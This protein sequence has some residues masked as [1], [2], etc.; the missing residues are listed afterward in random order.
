M[1]NNLS[2]RFSHI[3]KKKNRTTEE[4]AQLL[5]KILIK[6]QEIKSICEDVNHNFDKQIIKQ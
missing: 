4:K 3:I 1:K 5:L 2:K 6:D